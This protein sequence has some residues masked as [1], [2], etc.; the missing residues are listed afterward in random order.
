[1]R[2]QYVL[3]DLDGTLTDP[4][5]GITNSIMHALKQYGI[6][7]KERSELYKFIG[8]PLVDSFNKYFGFSQEQANRAVDLY[9]EYFGTKGM[10]ENKVYTGVPEI[11]EKLK[12]EGKTL[13]IATSKPTYYAKQILEYFDLLKYFV[14]VAGSNMDGTRRAKGEVIQFAIDSCK[15]TKLEECI[16]VGDRE[17]DII[18][19]KECNI[20][21]VGVLYG[22]GDK[23]ELEKA[24]ADYIVE[25]VEGI[26]C[27]LKEK[28]VNK[29]TFNPVSIR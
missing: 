25:M 12:N 6:T 3:F 23:E 29:D 7:V 26:N 4:A 24:G 2:Y 27:L 22:Y 16:M 13:V 28:D 14:F 9:R 8:P 21:S 11:L 1:M 15:I 10:L 5:V 19:A 17:H 20:D 18:G